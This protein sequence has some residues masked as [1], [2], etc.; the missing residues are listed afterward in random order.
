MRKKSLI[1]LSTLVGGV[2]M[3]MSAPA[4][5]GPVVDPA[6]LQP[7]PPPGAV[8]RA[9]GPWTICQTV[10]DG[11]SENAPAFDL[12][13]GTVYE[14]FRDVRE[15]IRWYLD[16]KLVKR[17]VSQNADG[18]WSLSP[19][20]AGPTVTVTAQANWRNEYAVPGDES[21]GPT[22]FH[23]NGVVARAPGFGVIAHIAG[24]DLPDGTHHGVVRFIDDPQVAAVLCEA[25]TA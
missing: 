12:P 3:S 5:A 15:G 24:L 25:L 2:L 7:V 14:T 1:A 18:S 16:G 17:F 13:C 22:V 21:S 6:T 10:F 23:G 9:D 20:G 19:T 11:S 4:L 8:C